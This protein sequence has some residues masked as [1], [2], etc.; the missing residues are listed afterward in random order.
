MIVDPKDRKYASQIAQRFEAIVECSNDAIISRDL[1]GTIT[2]WNPAA[3]RIFGYTAEEIIGKP[4]SVL[5]P[6]DR[7]DE[8][9]EIIRRI[10]RGERFDHYETVRR[11]K[12]GVL[13]NISLTVSPIK[14]AEGTV[15]GAS[16]IARDNTESKRAEEKQRLLFRE[17][18]HRV[19]NLLTL[20]GGIVTLSARSAK[21]PKDLAEQV[22]T[23]LKAV[24]SAHELMLPGL[25]PGSDTSKRRTDMASL[26]RTIV[27]P[28]SELDQG[29]DVRITAAGPDISIEK[30]PSQAGLCCCTSS[31]QTRSN[32]ARCPLPMATS[33][34]NGRCR[35]IICR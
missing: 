9:S 34:S 30:T 32:M 7:Q 18:N 28:Y 4:V 6:L 31:R 1:L 20:A 35:M 13:V 16:K 25:V 23:R 11:R 14:D 26:I 17:M 10:R 15:V 8:E 24:A 2:T 27:A 29:N 12:D 33:I 22:R 3:T 21:S 5:I 19:N